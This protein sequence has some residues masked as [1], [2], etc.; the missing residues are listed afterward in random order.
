ML[1]FRL[2]IGAALLLAL[3][4]CTA[5]VEGRGDVLANAPV[6][7]E[8][9]VATSALQCADASV[10][11]LKLSDSETRIEV[12]VDTLS[13]LFEGYPPQ[14]CRCDYLD[15]GSLKP[16][17]SEL[18]LFEPA[19]VGAPSRCLVGIGQVRR[20]FEL[21]CRVVT[22][23]SSP[24]VIARS[25]FHTVTPAPGDALP[26]PEKGEGAGLLLSQPS[27]QPNAWPADSTCGVPTIS[28]VETGATAEDASE[29]EGFD[30]VFG[31]DD[32]AAED[33]AAG[34]ALNETEKSQTSSTQGGVYPVFGG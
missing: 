33:A 30:E 22:D 8:D 7:T 18:S 19:A 1:S 23:L 34:G 12:T 26:D 4:A 5:P 16:I 25:V 31:S 27:A 6:E 24:Q 2:W 10:A 21:G 9:T 28:R 29:Q 32:S 17:T 15:N 20:G 11:V 14:G 13:S 3:V